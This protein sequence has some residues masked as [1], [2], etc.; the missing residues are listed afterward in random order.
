M[1]NIIGL[2]ELRT[3]P[4][5]IAIRTA[6]GESFLVMKRTKLLFEINPARQNEPANLL[7][8]WR[9]LRGVLKGKKI[10]DPVKWQ[11]RIRAE[12]ER[13]FKFPPAN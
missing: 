3:N 13:S 10:E 1:Q 8:A 7:E 5:K 12:S 9:K 4:H 2:K 6:K 11:K